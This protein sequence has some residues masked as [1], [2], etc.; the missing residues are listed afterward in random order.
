[1]TATHRRYNTIDRLVVT[2]EVI[3]NSEEIKVAMMKFYEKHYRISRVEVLFPV[4]GLPKNLSGGTSV[5][6]EAYYR[7][8]GVTYC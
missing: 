6:A 4:C 8:R 5:D 2:G 1:M 7:S 3:K